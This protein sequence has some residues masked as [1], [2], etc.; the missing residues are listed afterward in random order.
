MNPNETIRLLI[1]NDAENEAERIISLL[2]NNGRPT[3]AQHILSDDELNKALN[4]H[5]WDL[6]LLL[7]SEHGLKPHSVYDSIRHHDKDIPVVV[8]T[9]LWN[10]DVLIEGIKQGARD[11]VDKNSD[12]HLL[13]VLDREADSTVHKRERKANERRLKETERRCELLL[14]SSR[15]AI[16]YVHG[17]MHIYANAAYAEHFAYQDRDE[18]ECLPVIDMI[19]EA[20]QEKFKTFLKQ[21]EVQGSGSDQLEFLGIR[22]DGS[23]FKAT[24][25]LTPA[26]YDDEPCT[27][28]LIRAAAENSAELQEQLQVISRQDLLTGLYNRNHLMEQLRIAVDHA[29]NDEQYATLYYA[30]IDQFNQVR[31]SVGLSGSDLVLNDFAELLRKQLPENPT[32]ARFG[33]DIFSFMVPGADPDIA[34][35]TAK[36]IGRA[37][38]EHLFQV[39][40]QTVQ[41][42]C[43]IGIALINENAEDAD[44]LITRAHEA[45]DQVRE[46]NKAGNG[47]HLY[48]PEIPAEVSASI[49]NQLQKALDEGKFKLLF[50]PIISLRGDAEEHYEVLLRMLND[51]NEEVSPD[52][53]IENANRLGVSSKLDRWVI[54]E[55]IKMLSEHRSNGFNT[56]LTINLTSNSMQDQTLL[57]WLSV[58]FKA[59]RLPTESVIFQFTEV[60]VT[61]YL[62]YAQVFTAGLQELHCQVCISQFGCSL[63]P[64]NTLKH[65][66]CSYVK[67]DGSFTLDIQNNKENPDGLTGLVRQVQAMGKQTIVPFVE[68]ASVLST[69]W[70]AGVNYI[71]GHY[72]QAPS[73]R[74]DYDFSTEDD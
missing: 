38:E 46:F 5:T 30:N 56:K 12:D 4:E 24:M 54:L 26:R 60:D 3:R 36:N 64:M 22:E 45:A 13:L 11:V 40:D 2:R 10:Q 49:D 39:G 25:S 52:S 48:E 70:Q 44:T 35:V 65:V 16:A 59:A 57:P 23:E 17:G 69:L 58:A 67:M 47:V 34:V 19:A 21:H 1:V 62:K 28:M 55:S 29:C 43:S 51:N 53:F 68:N 14:D 15:D 63:N 72:L 71:Q 61:N 50:Q 41:V 37:I 20:D 27:Q 73:E 31:S 8:L 9:S 66:T 33:D 42:T 74:M 32:L 7:E 18:I 6:L